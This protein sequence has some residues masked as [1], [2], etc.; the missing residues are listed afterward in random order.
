[1]IFRYYIKEVFKE[2]LSSKINFVFIMLALTFSLTALNTIYALGKSAEKQILD[3]LANLNF[4]KDALLI[5]AGGQRMFGLTDTRTDTLKLLDAEAIEKLSCVKTTTAFT[6]G[7]VEMAFKGRAEKVR[8]DGI[9]PNYTIANNWNLYIGRFIQEED[10]KNLN[11][12]VVLGYEV[13]KRFGFNLVGE[14]IKIQ[15]QYYIVIGILEKKGSVG[16]FPLDERIFVPLTTAQ[17]RILNQDYIRGIK[18]ILQERADLNRCAEEIRKILRKRHQI[19]GFAP[20]DFR[21]ITP[22]LIVARHMATSRTLNVFLLNIAF[23]SLIISGVIIMNLMMASVEEKAGIIALRRAL[24]A[25][26]YQII[27]H[28]LLMALI[29][30]IISGVTC[31]ILSMFLMILLSLITPL[32]P[33]FS[34]G[35]FLLSIIFSTITCVVFSIFPALKATKIDPAILLKS[36]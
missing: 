15:D 16:H 21:I 35:T 19:Q 24:G 8:L 29:M 5:L 23:I 36:L 7:S 3:T 32:K 4:G 33:L 2:L 12:V 20:D 25:T 27:T 30:A 34:W 28:Y 18:V 26:S 11:K 10:I 9:Q 22:D 31:W 1:M 14:K 6:V 17:R 13:A